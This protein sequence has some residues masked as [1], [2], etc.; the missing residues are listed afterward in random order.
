MHPSPTIK[1]VVTT[2]EPLKNIV[3]PD[4]DNEGVPIN[5]PDI[6]NKLSS[7]DKALVKQAENAAREYMRKAGDMGN[8]PNARSIT[9]LNKK[10]YHSS[11]QTDQYNPDRLVGFVEIEN[12][13]LDV[14]DPYIEGHDE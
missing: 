10:G 2:L 11:L 14:S 4:G 7:N 5:S 8:E 9:E 12:W 13:R 6:Y 3:R 1:D